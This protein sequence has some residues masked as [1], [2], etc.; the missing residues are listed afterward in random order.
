MSKLQVSDSS[1]VDIANATLANQLESRLKEL[2]RNIAVARQFI[3]MADECYSKVKH[4]WELLQQDIGVK[5]AT[6]HQTRL[7]S[8][9]EDAIDEAEVKGT[10]RR[11]KNSRSESQR[12]KAEDSPDT[13]LQ[14]ED[15]AESAKDE[16]SSRKE[17][18]TFSQ[19]FKSGK[20]SKKYSKK[21]Q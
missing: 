15:H 4:E 14:S 8:S 16:K 18:E 2:E 17:S 13:F 19:G 1:L 9:S 10:A 20:K 21:T 11:E 12:K 5:T 3:G 6:T 7:P